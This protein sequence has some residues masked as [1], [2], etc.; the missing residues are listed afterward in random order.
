MSI[1]NASVEEIAPRTY[2]AYLNA[3]TSG[4]RQIV[5]I[6]TGGPGPTRSPL[7]RFSW[8]SPRVS[9]SD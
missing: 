9:K 2:S 4:G 7:T 5:I 3:L 8:K 6:S 1:V